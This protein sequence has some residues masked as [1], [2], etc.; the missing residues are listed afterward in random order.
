MFDR[1]PGPHRPTRRPGRVGRVTEPGLRRSCRRSRCAHLGQE[2]AGTQGERARQIGTTRRCDGSFLSRIGD[3]G[4]MAPST[5]NTHASREPASSALHTTFFPTRSARR[6]PTLGTTLGAPP[7]A[8][9]WPARPCA[10]GESAPGDRPAR[11]PTPADASGPCPLDRVSFAL[12]RRRHPEPPVPRT[13]RKPLTGAPS[14]CQRSH[15]SPRCT[16]GPTRPSPAGPSR[17][18]VSS[19]RPGGSGLATGL[20]A[21][22]RRSGWR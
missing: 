15:L 11:A 16:P 9:S 21:I 8:A 18:G 13:E 20:S 6:P 10:P 7:E 1:H 3:G 14:S 12:L 19:A 5:L 2:T 17:S 4:E 22:E